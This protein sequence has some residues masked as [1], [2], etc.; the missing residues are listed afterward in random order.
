MNVTLSSLRVANYLGSPFMNFAR[1]QRLDISNTRLNK[2]SNHFLTNFISHNINANIETSKF[3]NFMK[4]VVMFNKENH[5]GT[6][7]SSTFTGG[8]DQQVSFH[9]CTF[10]RCTN[11]NFGGAIN[12]EDPSFQMNITSSSFIS[13]SAGK[14]GGAIYTEV[15]NSRIKRLLFNKCHAGESCSYQTFLIT[16][17]G[18]ADA[19]NIQINDNGH[20]VE[21]DSFCTFNLKRGNVNAKQF[22]VTNNVVYSFGAALTATLA[23]K[24]RYNLIY[25]NFIEN[26]CQ[27][28]ELFS[29][30]H[31]SFECNLKYCN[32]L[33]NEGGS[34]SILFSSV[35]NCHC[36]VYGCVILRNKVASLAIINDLN[37]IL[38]E[39]CVCDVEQTGPR[40]VHNIEVT[41]KAEDF[42]TIQIFK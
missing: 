24:A 14:D 15:N 3:T 32:V 26:H 10:E 13:C 7:F 36:T 20:P 1:M 25:S 27:D 21:S 38:F 35:G 39:H 6:K 9:K 28:R 16:L 12:I 19:E 2:F 31:A 22:N 33:G 18:Q 41:F 37:L 11:S 34:Q 42:P 29:L 23:R 17:R 40:T 5:V 4:S 8:S 30:Y